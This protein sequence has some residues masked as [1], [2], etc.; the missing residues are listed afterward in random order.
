MRKNLKNNAEKVWRLCFITLLLHPHS[1]EN[2]DTEIM[3]Q[4]FLEKSSEIIWKFKRKTLIFASTFAKRK[5]QKSSLRDLHNST[6]STSIG[7]EILRIN[8]VN[9]SMTLDYDKRI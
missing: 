9:R 1:R 5:R 4:I 6:S 7:E 3:K 8:T 2:G